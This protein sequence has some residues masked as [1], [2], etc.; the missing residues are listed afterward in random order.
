MA[1]TGC[2]IQRVRK[3]AAVSSG[4][5]S[6]PP[7]ARNTVSRCSAAAGQRLSK[8]G[9]RVQAVVVQLLA[10]PFPRKGLN[11]VR[12]ADRTLRR[13]VNKCVHTPSRKC[14]PPP[15]AN[16]ATSLTGCK[17]VRSVTYIGFCSSIRGPCGSGLHCI[18]YRGF[19]VLHL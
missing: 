10:Q 6:D 14:G 5:R 11:V 4:L 17:S 19:A 18:A 13:N 12:A 3:A 2:T 8:R 9:S 7:T 1:S 16:C 15:R